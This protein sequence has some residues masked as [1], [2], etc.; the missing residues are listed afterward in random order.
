MTPQIGFSHVMQDKETIETEGKTYKRD[1]DVFDTWFSSGQW[2]YLTLN[3]P[4]GDDYNY[5][6]PTQF[7][8]MGKDIFNQWAS[9][10]DY[11]RPL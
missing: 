4:D 7:M 1:E 3:Y 9:T 2:P 11:A 6:Y 10:D 5:F 8:G